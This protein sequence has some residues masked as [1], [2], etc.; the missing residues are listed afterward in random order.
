LACESL[1][2]SCAGVC[3]VLGVCECVSVLS[4][5]SSNMFALVLMSQLLM[6][7][8]AYS[9][10]DLVYPPPLSPHP[11]RF[12]D[13]PH[14]DTAMLLEVAVLGLGVNILGIVAFS[15]AHTHGGEPCDHGHSQSPTPSPQKS[16]H[17][18]S[19]GGVACDGNHGQPP[20]KSSHGHSHGG[21]ACDGHHD[22]PPSSAGQGGA[23]AVDRDGFAT[24]PLE[25]S[26]GHSHGGVACDGHHGDTPTVVVVPSSGDQIKGQ[27]RSFVLDGET[28]F[29]GRHADP[30]AHS[31]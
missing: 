25:S 19:H 5:V 27:Q 6:R 20:P 9:D 17:G 7:G 12:M 13:P 3:V 18:H 24:I 29:W 4:H 26:H 31:L 1:H 21:V 11:Q 16:S 10:N 28:W 23:R 8:R 30:L 22:G 14:V 15:H 2:G